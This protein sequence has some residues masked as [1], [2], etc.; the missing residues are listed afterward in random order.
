MGRAAG[1]P[2]T[3]VRGTEA[4]DPADRIRVAL[5]AAL[6]RVPGPLVAAVS[7]GADS[8][9]LLHALA[10]WGRRRFV[11]VATFDHG[12]GPAATAAAARVVAEAR[13]LGLTVVRERARSPGR[14][15]AEWRA[16]RW[17]FL[18][19]VARGWDARIVTA[20]TRDD[21]LETVVMRALRG[22][23][24]RGLAGLR[25]PS[26]VVRPWLDLPRS[27]LQ[28]WLRAEGIGWEEDP[29]NRS[30]RHLRVRVRLDL[31]PALERA[32]PGFGEA[33]LALGE[34]AA[35]WR[36]D[37]ER[38]VDAC[39]I[40]Q[41]PGGGLRVP[42]A[43]LLATT[44]EGRAVLWPEILARAGVVLD[45]HGTR[46]L[47]RFTTT[48]RPGARVVLPGGAE[49]VRVGARGEPAFL[50]VPPPSSAAPM[51]AWHG[52]AAAVPSRLGA[53]RFRRLSDAPDGYDVEGRLLALPRGARITVRPVLAGDRIRTRGAP[54]G[55]R[56][57]RY[58]AE[59][60]I[61]ARDRRGWPVVLVDDVIVAIPG[62]CRGLAAPPRPGRPDL[63][64]YWCDRD[65][66]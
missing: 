22:A 65:D 34:R 33:M 31:L 47:V 28:A 55:R 41:A 18:R 64:W 13:R 35:A 30:R 38:F 42:A 56:V 61:A 66:R 27:T 52:T 37:V 15:E 44:P 8:M 5:A 32:A 21:Q 63:L 36:A 1:F 46:A 19:R 62:V 51:V 60:G 45:R 50:L 49:V 25:A 29:E 57:V 58:L 20:H 7:G 3:G 10:R 43:P 14:N 26:A 48:R 39:G 59:A 17:E 11:A 40:R 2:D 6:D 9:A 54:A 16:A 4:A 53:W 12:T 24:A 23:G